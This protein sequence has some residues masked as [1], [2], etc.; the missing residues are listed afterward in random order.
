ML[1]LV[2]FAKVSG[3]PLFVKMDC[4]GCETEAFKDL[5]WLQRVDR[6]SM[7]WH[8]HDGD[9]FRD[10]LIEHGFEVE[11]EGG[12]PKP[13]PVWDKSIGGGLLHAKRKP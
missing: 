4:E 1:D 12:G 11:I 13:R 5:S 10:I 2:N 8:N 9:V 7:E 6:V 3:R